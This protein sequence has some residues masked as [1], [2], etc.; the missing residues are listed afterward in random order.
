[1]TQR[2]AIRRLW[3][4]ERAKLRDHLLRLDLDDRVLFRVRCYRRA[5]L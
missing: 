4:F 5:H 3:P 2:G 1:M